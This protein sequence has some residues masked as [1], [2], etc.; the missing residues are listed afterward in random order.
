MAAS[1]EQSIRLPE[2]IPASILETATQSIGETMIAAQALGG[3]QAQHLVAAGQAAFSAWHCVVL[4]S[5]AV[6]IAV[7]GVGVGYVLR[8]F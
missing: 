8:K 5:A 1:Y 2:G 3:E 7:L 4:L 6:L